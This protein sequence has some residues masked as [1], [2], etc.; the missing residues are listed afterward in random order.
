[1]HRLFLT[2]PDAQ[3]S[4]A[5]EQ[6]GKARHGRKEMR[7][8]WA[9]S[10]ALLNAHVGSSGTAEQPWPAGAQVCR[11]QRVIQSKDTASKTW[12]T[13]V[14]LAYAITSSPPDGGRRRPSAQTVV[15]ATA[16]RERTALGT[17][18][19]VWRRCES[20]VQGTSAGGVRYPAQCRQSLETTGRSSSPIRV[21]VK[22]PL[23]HAG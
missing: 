18:C 13:T 1:M 4:V 20:G 6:A 11:L 12:Q 17:Q 8:L 15:G 23:A 10:S 21:L 7:T 5:Q 2:L 16:D 22:W 19:H 9:L 3:L 14:E